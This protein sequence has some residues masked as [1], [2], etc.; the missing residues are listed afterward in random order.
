MPI[1]ERMEFLEDKIVVYTDTLAARAATPEPVVGSA[2]G[3]R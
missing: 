1:R 2:A 3:R